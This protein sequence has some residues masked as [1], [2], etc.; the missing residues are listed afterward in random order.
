[1]NPTMADASA[2]DAV[3]EGPV[4]TDFTDL[5]EEDR[6]WS[7]WQLLHVLFQALQDFSLSLE[8]FLPWGSRVE[9]PHNIR[10]SISGHHLIDPHHVGRHCDHHVYIPIFLCLIYQ[11]IHGIY[12]EIA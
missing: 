10:I 9:A 6:W 5:H 3:S 1:M 7:F 12:L 8:L 2:A 4:V 11:Q